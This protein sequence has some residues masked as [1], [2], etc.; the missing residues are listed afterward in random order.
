VS[1]PT[2]T[3][4]APTAELASSLGVASSRSVPG[5]PS[6]KKQP[7][8]AGYAGTSFRLSSLLAD[9]AAA[10]ATERRP[11]TAPLSIP[12]LAAGSPAYYAYYAAIASTSADSAATLA[13][14]TVA[15]AAATSRTPVG[16]SAAKIA[17]HVAAAPPHLLTGQSLVCC[18]AIP[19]ADQAPHAPPALMTEI[20]LSRCGSWV[21]DD[22]LMSFSGH[23]AAS[24]LPAP[25]ALATTA[26]AG[27]AVNQRPVSAGRRAAAAARAAS[28][29]ADSGKRPG[30]TATEDDAA[31]KLAKSNQ[32]RARMG[33]APEEVAAGAVGRRGSG[34][35]AGVKPHAAAASSAPNAAA[36][37]KIP[38]TALPMPLQALDLTDCHRLTDRSLA[39]IGA[40]CPDLEFLRLRLC[41]QLGLSDAAVVAVAQVSSSVLSRGGRGSRLQS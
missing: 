29:E 25:P 31:A 33:L 35:A 26:P 14:S 1:F 3:V 27:S 38:P 36:L 17:A 7:P 10:S 30:A 11:I 4:A 2:E 41:D 21:T 9:M 20:T 5:A 19:P 18:H 16:E 32:M 8:P 37:F 6:I 12:R 34:D 22:V 28:A 24:L 40:N 23:Y 39:F 13:P 15:G